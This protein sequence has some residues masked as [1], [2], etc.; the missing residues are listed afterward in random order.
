VRGNA[1]VGHGF[2]G[3]GADLD[4]DR[5][6]TLTF[7]DGVQGLVAV[8]LGNGDVVFELAGNGLVQVVHHAEGAITGVHIF[9]NDAKA[10]HVHDFGKR[11]CLSRIF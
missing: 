1:V 8:G 6:A 9:G 2:H 10:V 4:F 3:F 5:Y 7:Q 11:F